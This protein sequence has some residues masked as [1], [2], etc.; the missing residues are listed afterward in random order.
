MRDVAVPVRVAFL[1][2]A[3]NAVVMGLAGVSAPVGWVLV[4]GV[5]GA[6]ARPRAA[7]LVSA[8]AAV[9]LALSVPFP[10]IVGHRADG[11]AVATSA[12]FLA[13][14][15]LLSWGVRHTRF[16]E[17]LQRSPSVTVVGV[18]RS[19]RPVALALARV[20]GEV[21]A[22]VEP[23]AGGSRVLLGM[24][25]GTDDDPHDCVSAVERVFRTA[26]GPLRAPLEDIAKLLDPVVRQQ[27]AGGYLAATLVDIGP[28]GR[29]HT[30]RCGS[31]EIFAVPASHHGSA[32]T[33]LLVVDAGPG[34]APLGFGDWSAGQACALPDDARIVI[35]TFRYLWAYHDDHLGPLRVALR[36]SDPKTAA[37]KLLY[38][39]PGTAAYNRIIGPALIVDPAPSAAR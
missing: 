21:A 28:D 26:A 20:S 16:M 12:I 14:V 6:S 29:V 18:G 38:G 19:A 25:V 8:W 3:G 1:V 33:S 22:V 5:A 37:T 2:V 11:Q 24:V 9:L 4:P 35:V 17:R 39:P 23:P 30:L 27:A 7:I 13:L 36:D 34:A 10:A 32:S 31:P 15:P